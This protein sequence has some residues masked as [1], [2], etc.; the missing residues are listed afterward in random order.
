MLH[1][2]YFRASH[3]NSI[4]QQQH[5]NPNHSC[6]E[7]YTIVLWEFHKWFSPLHLLSFCRLI[8]SYQCDGTWSHLTFCHTK[9]VFS[10]DLLKIILKLAWNRILSVRHKW[11]KA[12]LYIPCPINTLW[13]WRIWNIWNSNRMHTTI[14]SAKGQACCSNP[15]WK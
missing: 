13:D 2:Q 3:N 4:S 11:S 9:I 12:L 15:I 14:H 6:S 5:L 1:P 10:V 7:L 8:I